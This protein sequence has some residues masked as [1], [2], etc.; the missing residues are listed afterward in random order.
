MSAYRKFDWFWC[1][2]LDRSL[3]CTCIL[4]G[5]DLRVGCL[6]KLL[7]TK[8]LTSNWRTYWVT[9]PHKWSWWSSWMASRHLLPRFWSHKGTRCHK[10]TWPSGTHHICTL[11]YMRRKASGTRTKLWL[12]SL[13]RKQTCKL[14]SCTR[15]LQRMVDEPDNWL[16]LT[17]LHSRLGFFWCFVYSNM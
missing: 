9:R 16:L 8:S 10:R 4:E 14:Y 6:S 7:L 13:V 3:Q 15:S 17:Y 2:V 5:G 1:T 12:S 11:R